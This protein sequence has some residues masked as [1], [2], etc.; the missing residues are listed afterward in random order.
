[1]SWTSSSSHIFGTSKLLI[2]FATSSG[3]TA[4]W[5][6]RA[7][8]NSHTT[9]IS[10]MWTAKLFLSMVAAQDIPLCESGK[11]AVKGNCVHL[12]GPRVPR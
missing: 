2:P 1:M 12:T 7:I 9:C 6:P 8:S 3:F 5:F 4:M 11:D 10:A